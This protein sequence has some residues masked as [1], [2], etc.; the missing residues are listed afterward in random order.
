MYKEGVRY[1]DIHT[2][3]HAYTHTY[4]Y[5]GIFLSHEKNEIMPLAAT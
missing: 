3:I 4:T 2:H 5:N 1:I